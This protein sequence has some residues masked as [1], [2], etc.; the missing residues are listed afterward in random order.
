MKFLG[1]MAVDCSKKYKRKLFTDKP[2]LSARH[3]ALIRSEKSMV[4][5]AQQ[6]RQK[7][8]R[9]PIRKVVRTKISLDRKRVD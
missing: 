5:S 2:P 4:K 1:F 9:A 8:R 3:N 7:S 6:M